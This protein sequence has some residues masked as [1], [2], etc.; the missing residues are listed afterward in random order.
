MEISVDITFWALMEAVVADVLGRLGRV[1]L[2]AIDSITNPLLEISQKLVPA[3]QVT[4]RSVQ[5]SFD[6][7]IEDRTFQQYRF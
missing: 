6:C 2:L 7:D 1:I 4:F 5:S 3:D